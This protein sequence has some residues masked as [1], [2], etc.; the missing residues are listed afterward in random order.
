[1]SEYPSRYACLVY[2]ARS[3]S[4]VCNVA[5]AVRIGNMLSNLGLERWA[6]WAHGMWDL[7]SEEMVL[8]FESHHGQL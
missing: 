7:W 6:N 3:L 2:M 1:M 8:L 4:L 5:C